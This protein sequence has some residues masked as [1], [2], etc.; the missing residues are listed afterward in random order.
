MND[1]RKKIARKICWFQYF[2]ISVF[3]IRHRI[4]STNWHCKKKVDDTDGFDETIKKKSTLKNC[5]K[6]DLIYKLII[7]FFKYYR[8]NKK[9]Y[10]LSF[11]WNHSFLHEFLDN[12]NKFSDL[13][14]RNKNTKIK[15]AKVQDTVLELYSKFLD[16]SF[17]EYYDLEKGTKENL[18]YKWYDYGKLFNETWHENYDDYEVEY[19]DLPDM[20]PLENDREDVKLLKDYK[21]W[22]QTNY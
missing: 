17:D 13:K 2:E 12:I 4:K 20:P 18:G 5:C 21:F 19:I 14:P 10:N 16:I 7:A 15:K 11:K 9:F 1:T 22:L 6:S 3:S 8:E